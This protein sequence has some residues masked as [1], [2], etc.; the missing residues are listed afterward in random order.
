M[1]TEEEFEASL[2]RVMHYWTDDM[3]YEVFAEQ[4]ERD[5]LRE[6]LHKLY[7]ATGEGY[8]DFDDDE[9]EQTIIEYVRQRHG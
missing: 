3:I 7:L 6:P 5:P 4:S 9:D 1:I 2:A 8:T